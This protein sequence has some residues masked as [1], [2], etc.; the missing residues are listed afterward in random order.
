MPITEKKDGE[1]MRHIKISTKQ[2][3]HTPIKK[4]IKSKIIVAGGV[5]HESV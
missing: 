1:W 5:T 3:I 2:F 4:D